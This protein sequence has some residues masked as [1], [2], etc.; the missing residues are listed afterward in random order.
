MTT[1]EIF[2][3]KRKRRVKRMEIDEKPHEGSNLTPEKLFE[4]LIYSVLDTLLSRIDWWYQKKKTVC[5]DCIFFN[6]SSFQ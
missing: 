4:I 2:L 3:N 6:G 5:D 1:E